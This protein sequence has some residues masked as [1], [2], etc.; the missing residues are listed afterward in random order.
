MYEDMNII[1]YIIMKSGYHHIHNHSKNGAV[2]DF[3]N[4]IHFMYDATNFIFS[5]KIVVFWSWFLFFANL[6]PGLQLFRWTCGC[7]DLTS[8]Q[9][10]LNR[11]WTTWIPWCGMNQAADFVPS[12]FSYL[13]LSFLKLD[14]SFSVILE[15]ILH[16]L[17]GGPASAKTLYLASR[18]LIDVEQA[19]FVDVP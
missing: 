16:L 4:F 10:R 3:H 8:G 13:F 17:V 6:R 12:N 7:Q 15:S 5:L 9:P 19:E 1:Y 11:S 18:D 2:F 14:L